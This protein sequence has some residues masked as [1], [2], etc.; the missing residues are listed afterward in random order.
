VDIDTFIILRGHVKLA[1]HIVRKVVDLCSL[2]SRK[3]TGALISRASKLCSCL[4]YQCSV[5]NTLQSRGR[6]SASHCYS[7]TSLLQSLS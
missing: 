5:A 7:F 1:D 4:C 3:E 6:S 2:H